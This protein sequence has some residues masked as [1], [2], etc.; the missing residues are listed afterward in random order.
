MADRALIASTGLMAGFTLAVTF[1]AS[2]LVDISTKK[3]DT[4]SRLYENGAK[5]AVPLALTTAI[6]GGMLYYKT[7]NP[8]ILAAT[9]I[10]AFPIPFT[11]LAMSPTNKAIEN[12]SNNDPKVDGL[13]NKWNQLHNVRTLVSVVSFGLAVYALV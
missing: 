3:R 4:W 12:S 1:V 7:P 10:G 6:S 9:I 11:V 5:M 13:V 8:R 2:P